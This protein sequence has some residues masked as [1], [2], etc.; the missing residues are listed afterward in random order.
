MRFWVWR[1][2]FEI[3]SSGVPDGSVANVTREA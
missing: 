1:A 2:S 3:R